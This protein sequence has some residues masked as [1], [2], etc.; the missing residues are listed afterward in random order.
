[1]AEDKRSKFCR[2]CD[3]LIDWDDPSCPHC[4]E[5]LRLESFDDMEFLGGAPPPLPS[6]RP[7]VVQPIGPSSRGSTDR[8]PVLRPISKPGSPPVVQ[9]IKTS[10]PPVVK[11]AL[12]VA[13]PI[14][15]GK[16]PV[17]RPVS[18]SSRAGGPP[19]VQPIADGDDSPPVIQPLDRGP[20]ILPPM[21]ARAEPLQDCPVCEV[22]LNDIR[23]VGGV[24]GS[25]GE[26]VCVACLLKANGGKASASSVVNR[27]RWS[28]HRSRLRPIQI[29][30]AAC[31]RAGV[32]PP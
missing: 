31:G 28:Q 3:E 30:C 23:N 17:I 26:S 22:E 27:E 5:D 13:T 15:P 1:M 24:C 14:Y 6:K 18:P 9:P 10:G 8:P 32:D 19:T 16:P 29:R 12:P 11:P 2:Y 21:R 4:G 7:P 25:C 20:P